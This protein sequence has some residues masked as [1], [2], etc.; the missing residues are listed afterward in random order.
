MQLG[1]LTGYTALYIGDDDSL[2]EYGPAYLKADDIQ[3][4]VVDNPIKLRWVNV[5]RLNIGDLGCIRGLFMRI[6]LP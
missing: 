3:D 5:K 2:Y 1:G 4:A 6:W